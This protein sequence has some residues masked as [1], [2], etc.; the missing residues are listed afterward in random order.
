MLVMSPASA[1][2]QAHAYRPVVATKSKRGDKLGKGARGVRKA[3]TLPKEV[4]FFCTLLIAGLL[5]FY[6]CHCIWVS[7]EMYSAP[8]IV[9][10]TRNSDG[11]V[12][13][14]DDFREA[15]AWLRFVTLLLAM[16]FFLCTVATG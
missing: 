7:A 9:L 2:Q 3:T 13:T 16:Q 5:L 10:Q 1:P 6:A 12:R 11:S 8:S 14:L 4:S 15:Y